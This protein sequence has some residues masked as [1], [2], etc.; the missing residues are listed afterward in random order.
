METNELKNQTNTDSLRLKVVQRI[1]L[2]VF[3]CIVTGA[4]TLFMPGLYYFLARTETPP[5]TSTSPFIAIIPLVILLLLVAG[6]GY[7]LYDA[8]RLFMQYRRSKEMDE[9][10]FP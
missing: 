3:G 7:A 4:A 5:S 2:L 1:L 9:V 8:I 6:L 10:M